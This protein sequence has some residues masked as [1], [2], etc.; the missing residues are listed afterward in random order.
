MELTIGLPLNKKKNL[1]LFNN[2][3]TLMTDEYFGPTATQLR[4]SLMFC[5][6]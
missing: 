6:A 3:T 1:T 4:S 5:H 2:L